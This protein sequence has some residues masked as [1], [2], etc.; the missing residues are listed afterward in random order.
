V[1]QSQPLSSSGSTSGEEAGRP[2]S[3]DAF[4]SS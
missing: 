3:V 4:Y 2:K 1:T